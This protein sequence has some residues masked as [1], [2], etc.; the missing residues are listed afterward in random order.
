MHES[1]KWKW[2]RSVVSDSSRPHGV[3][4]TRLIHPWDFSGKSTGVGCHCLLRCFLQLGL[5]LVARY[6]DYLSVRSAVYVLVCL[7]WYEDTEMEDTIF[8][9]LK[10]WTFSQDHFKGKIC[11]TSTESCPPLLFKNHVNFWFTSLFKLFT[12]ITCDE[13]AITSYGSTWVQSIVIAVSC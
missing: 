7:F 12:L 3:Q 2:I 9:L 11:Y 10:T 5:N 1:E 6:G 8:N 13:E 4:P